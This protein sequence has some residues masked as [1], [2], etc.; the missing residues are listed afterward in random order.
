MARIIDTS[1]MNPEDLPPWDRD[2][3]YNGLDCCVT[4]EVLEALLPQLEPSTKLAYDFSR[5]LM[6]PV[7]DMR[8]RGILVDKV[9]KQEVLDLYEEQLDQLAGQLDEIVLNG[10]GMHKFSWTSNDDLKEVFY[11]RLGIPPVMKAGRETVDRNALEKI[12]LYTVAQP[13]MNHLFAM[14]DL[15]AKIKVLRKPDDDDGRARTSLN[16][17]G[18]STFR[19]SS[20]SEYETGGNFQNIE[21]ALRSIFIA[22]WGWKFVKVDGE[23]I[24]S[25]VVGAI[26]G[27]ELGDWTYLDACESGDLHTTV[28]KMVW[29]DLPWTGDLAADRKIAEEPYYRH[30]DRR[31]MCKKL[32]HGSNFF[33]Q[34]PTLAAQS[35]VP[36]LLVYDFQRGYYVRFPGHEGWKEWTKNQLLRRG[37]GY[38]IGIGGRKRTFWGRRWDDKTLRDALAHQAQEGESKIV[39]GAMLNIWRKDYCTVMHQD[40][41]ALIFMY[42]EEEENEVVPRIL[43]DL[44]YPI[45]LTRS[46]DL[47]V[48]FDCKVGWN[49]GEYCCG[50]KASPG[51]KDC[52]KEVNLDGLRKWTPLLGDGGRKRQ[53]PREIISPLDRKRVA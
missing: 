47:L 17:C 49:R 37:G 18:T 43:K 32:G 50:N 39:N 7:L 14:K 53:P 22:D 3:V 21:E 15:F 45:K 52:K 29:K 28:A 23:Q 42:R 48:P 12:D 13:I 8:T 33:G 1:K 31:F 10:L 34:P 38:I 16:I 26:E 9:R 40:H 27:K 30:Y 51:C 46:R 19:F 6:G 24:Q 4:A 5:Q 41:D 35:R 11:R 2:Q 25:R 36:E 20:S 44:E